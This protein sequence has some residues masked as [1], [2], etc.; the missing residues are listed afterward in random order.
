MEG[1][2]IMKRIVGLFMIIAL[3]L[4]LVACGSSNKVSSGGDSNLK[5]NSSGS[6]KTIKI[7]A[8]VQAPPNHP[9]YKGLAKWKELVEKRS[10][11]QIKVQLYHDTQLGDDKTMIENTQIGSQ[12]VALPSTSPVTNFV[13]QYK[14]FDFP[15]LFPNVKVAE[16]VLDGKSG[17][18]MLDLLKSKN[19]VGLAFFE[20]GF[21]DVTNNKHPIKTLK[22]FKD[23]KIR[24]MESELTVKVFKALGANPTPMSYSELFTAL[25]QGVVDAQENPVT[26]IYN[27]HLYEV[28]KHFS[29]TN[30][31]YN[32]V[33][34]T[35]GKKFY[36]GL[37]K[38]NQKI[39]KD[40]AQEATVYER[41]LIRKQNNENVEKLKKVGMKI[42]KVTPEAREE[43]T[44][45]IQ[46]IIKK[47]SGEIGGD[48]VNQMYEAI[49]KAEKKVNE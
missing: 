35:M 3:V 30:H 43:M 47:A 46:P 1:E 31:L 29:D 11:G 9:L 10:N 40:A 25:Q 32:A 27:D 33:V 15:F 20:N 5:G 34:F 26:T 7:R 23:L 8:G 42:T 45:T 12:E 28:Q 41:K 17:K 44:K 39:V 21:R 36:D 18:K 38:E 22:D 49:E 37:S 24:T 4:G 2:N 19:L 13:P 6:K 16:T 48:L 14:I